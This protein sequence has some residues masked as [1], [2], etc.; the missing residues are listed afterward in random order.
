MTR[1]S[2]LLPGVLLALAAGAAV[3][4]QAQAR[5]VVDS[6]G[7][8]RLEVDGGAVRPG[9]WLY[10]FSLRSDSGSAMPVV[11]PS[12]SPRVVPLARPDTG[13]VRTDTGVVKTE[14]ALVQPNTGIVRGDSMRVPGDSVA[15]HD[16]TAR[17]DSTARQAADALVWRDSVRF[18]GEVEVAIAPSDYGGMPSWLLTETG[19]RDGAIVA[20]SLWLTRSQLRPQH[21]AATLGNA[22]L[23]LEFVRDTIYGATSSPVRRRS[24]LLAEP[25]DLLVNGAMTDVV[26]RLLPLSPHVSDSVSVLVVDIGGAAAPPA[27]L[28][29]V[30]EELVTAV[31][32]IYDAWVVE[33]ETERG[34]AT[35]WVRKADSVVLRAEQRLPQLGGMV[36]RRELVRGG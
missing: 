23:A 12:A 8:R 11:P 6:T 30:G 32:G 33:L 34:R 1:Y 10:T 25:H 35:F 27:K 21:W 26:L 17:R 31:A 7:S 15:R 36:L 18:L 19:V 20:D 16:G 9:R 24:V 29:V 14:P 2:A 5:I 13:V 28:T 4:A 3:P 22:A